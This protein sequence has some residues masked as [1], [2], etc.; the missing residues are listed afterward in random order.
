[1]LPAK[2]PHKLTKCAPQVNEIKDHFSGS[3]TKK[4]FQDALQAGFE[5]FAKQ[6]TEAEDDLTFVEC[7]NRCAHPE[8]Q[9]E[10]GTWTGTI[11][12]KPVQGGFQYSW[13]CTGTYKVV[14][15]VPKDE[16]R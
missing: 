1:M 13:K 7:P 16:G 15:S 14:C 9:S 5:T 6:F 2:T 3:V 12:V 4:T 8:P 10:G 11:D